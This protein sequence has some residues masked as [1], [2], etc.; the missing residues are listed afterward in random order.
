MNIQ[1]FN[2]VLFDGFETLD[3]FG[4]AEIMGELKEN[5]RLNYFSQGG[6]IVQSSQSIKVE[7]LPFSQMNTQGVLLIPGGIGTRSLV[8]DCNFVD[9]LSKLVHKA[10]FVLTVCTG[11]ALLAKTGLLN[12]RR[13]TANKEVFDWV[14]SQNL[15][16]KWQRSARWV[17]DGPIYTSSGVSAGMDMALGFVA[18][19]H[20]QRAALDIARRLEYLWN[21][22]SKN[23]PFALN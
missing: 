15:H 9:E 21:S 8:D 10:E 4:P 16:V 18:E 11:S 22:D 7:T 23:D 6:G 1:D 20:G 3:A 13:A 2:F 17:V 12:G 14:C 5:Y 19:L